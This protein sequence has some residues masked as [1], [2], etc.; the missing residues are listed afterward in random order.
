MIIRNNAQD[1]MFNYLFLITTLS[2]TA[3]PLYFSYSRGKNIN[4]LDQKTKAAQKP[5]FEHLDIV[6]VGG[7]MFVIFFIQIL[8]IEIPNRALD[9]YAYIYIARNLTVD[10]TNFMATPPWLNKERFVPR[11]VFITLIAVFCSFFGFEFESAEL[12]IIASNIMLIPVVFSFTSTFYDKKVGS[13]A[14]PLIA[15]NP[16]FWLL[17]IRI[18]P[19]ITVTVFSWASFYFL[20]KALKNAEK[21]LIALKYVIL[22]FLF[23]LLALFTKNTAILLIPA[24]LLLFFVYT[25]NQITRREKNFF[26]FYIPLLMISVSIVISLLRFWPDI[27]ASI[28]YFSTKGEGWS[29]KAIYDTMIN[30]LGPISQFSVLILVGIFLTLK[31][32]SVWDKRNMTILVVAWAGYV[33]FFLIYPHFMPDKRHVF[34]QQVSAT[35]IAAFGIVSIS[36]QRKLWKISLP[37]LILAHIIDESLTWKGTRQ[38]SILIEALLLII[39]L[40]F[41]EEGI[42]RTAQ[43]NTLT[44]HS[45]QT[46]ILLGLTLLAFA[47]AAFLDR[48]NVTW[49]EQVRDESR[50]QAAFFLKNIGR[51]FKSHKIGN[52]SIMTN[53]YATLPY[54]AGFVPVYIPPEV[55]TEF[56]SC[57]NQKNITFLVL[58]WGTRSFLRHVLGGKTIPDEAPY[59][60]KYV[61]NPLPNARLVYS[62]KTQTLENKEVGVVIF[63]IDI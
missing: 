18:Y 35:I 45:F 33:L 28:E 36:K 9:E 2:I 49:E 7:I 30:P 39:T 63:K 4:R 50:V 8:V 34:S 31:S 61:W 38:S 48:Y 44:T 46:A 47:N 55:E 6:L 32:E 20:L 12:V 25:K 3:I 23:L 58:F 53:A 43:K 37:V 16:V 14:T 15:V 5:F 51:W 56:L 22:S 1:L 26:S 54:Y 59:L 24:F 27:I 62:D 19:D 57:L 13:V 41:L 21:D 29:L 42:R 52:E 17:S 60:E 11:Y 10:N 40:I